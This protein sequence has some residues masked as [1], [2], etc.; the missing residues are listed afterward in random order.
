MGTAFLY[1]NGGGGGGLNFKVTAYRD[2]QT[3]LAATPPNN[4]IGVVTTVKIGRYAFRPTRPTDPVEGLVWFCTGLTSPVA[5][6]ALKKNELYIYPQTCQQYISGAWVDVVAKSRLNGVWVDWWD[7]ELYVA[8]NEYEGV[9]G[10]WVA[11]PKGY[12]SSNNTT[13]TP[14]MIRSENSMTFKMS[15]PNGAIVCTKN[16]VNVTDYSTL[17]FDGVFSG[18]NGQASLCN[19]RVWGDIGSYSS[20]NS[21]ASKSITVDSN[22]TVTLDIADLSGEYYIGI[23]L[24]TQLVTV[25]MRSMY[26]E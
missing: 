9:T 23:A 26:M 17:V 6:N 19:I 10:G 20:G 22:G 1:G 14:E 4:T 7:G 18:T 21:V 5:F 12:D 3:L 15:G 2:E 8:G 11:I 13:G 24:W 16:K 25:T